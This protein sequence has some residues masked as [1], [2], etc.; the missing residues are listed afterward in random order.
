MAITYSGGTITVAGAK[1]TGTSTGGSSTTIVDT[2][3]SWTVDAY[4]GRIVWNRTDNYMG[5]ILSNTSNTLTVEN[6][7]KCSLSS[8]KVI[9]GTAASG[10]SYSI[11]YNFADLVADQPSYCSWENTTTADVCRINAKLNFSGNG[12]LADVSKSLHHIG[13]AQWIECTNQGGLF[14]MGRINESGYGVDGGTYIQTQTASGYP[15]PNMFSLWCMYG[16]RYEVTKSVDDDVNANIRY[17]LGDWANLD[18]FWFLDSECV[19]GQICL[20]STYFILRNKFF[21]FNNNI[22][23]PTNVYSGNVLQEGMIA[24]RGDDATIQWAGGDIFDATVGGVVVSG[25]ATNPI[26]VYRPER[27]D[28]AA[29]FW[30][31]EAPEYATENYIQWYTSGSPNEANVS[32]YFGHTIDIQVN[33][34]NGDPLEGVVL[35]L[36][37]T[38]G[39]AAWVTGKRNAASYYAPETS[40]TITTNAN[41]TYIGPFGTDEGGFVVKYKL[42]RIGTGASST[43]T[44]KTILTGHLRSGSMAMFHNNILVLIMKEVQKDLLV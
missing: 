20:N 30:N 11:C 36:Y 17:N 18:G 24:P 38:D 32:M 15:E 40:A 19:R 43:S 25:V 33:D 34:V 4:V 5:F 44:V 21:K 12:A 8:K 6:W 42:T 1:V 29:Y 35:G 3:K 23:G 22:Y 9:F 2:S 27:A 26:F 14:Q 37:D 28:Q 41:G 7:H 31:F 13:D 10:K 16:G 39:N